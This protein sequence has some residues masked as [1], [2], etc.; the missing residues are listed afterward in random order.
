MQD[1]LI[2]NLWIS[3]WQQQNIILGV[4]LPFWT[5]GSLWLH[6]SHAHDAGPYY[7]LGIFHVIWWKV[8]AET[9]PCSEKW[10]VWGHLGTTSEKH[11]HRKEEILS[12]F[13]RFVSLFLSST[14]KSQ[15]SPFFYWIHV[16]PACCWS[17]QMTHNFYWDFFL[18]VK[19]D[20]CYCNRS[21]SFCWV[22]R[23]NK[24]A[25]YPVLGLQSVHNLNYFYLFSSS[26]KYAFSVFIFQMTMILFPEM[27][28][29]FYFFN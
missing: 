19:L 14:F 24:I 18:L 16:L 9:Y 7:K 12:Q 17:I 8:L 10:P 5:Q 15:T 2:R 25:V 26:S 1:H 23:G 13:E 27:I 29:I 28:F 21:S 3:Q 20:H 6:G 11:E 4:L 22:F